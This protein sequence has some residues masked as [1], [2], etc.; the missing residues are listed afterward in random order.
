MQVDTLGLQHA[1][2]VPPFRSVR[3]AVGDAADDV[4][5]GEVPPPVRDEAD[6]HARTVG[7][8][9]QHLVHPHNTSAQCVDELQRAGEHPHQL[10]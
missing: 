7:E 8:E 3:G 4:G 9:T 2:D 1:Q 5:R 10:T 6:P